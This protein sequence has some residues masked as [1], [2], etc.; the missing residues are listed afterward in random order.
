MDPLDVTH[1][2]SALLEG[3]SLG[4]ARCGDTSTLQAYLF[5]SHSG[6]LPARLVPCACGTL[7]PR[8]GGLH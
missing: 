4:R 3:W 2:G 1:W 8:E 5:L 6:V 7:P